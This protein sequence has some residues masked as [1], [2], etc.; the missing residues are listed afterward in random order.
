MKVGS[1][2]QGAVEW[3]QATGLQVKVPGAVVAS[4]ILVAPRL[5]LGMAELTPQED[6][7]GDDDF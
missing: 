7:D 6:M 4:P 5:F 2:N 3:R 1:I